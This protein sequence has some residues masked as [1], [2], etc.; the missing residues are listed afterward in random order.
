MGN[1]KLE[2]AVRTYHEIQRAERAIDKK[3]QHLNKLVS[4]LTT[5]EIEEYVRRTTFNHSGECLSADGC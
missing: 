5:Y 1:S 3:S 4:T 2:V